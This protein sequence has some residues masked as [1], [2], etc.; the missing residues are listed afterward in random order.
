MPI[1]YLV[2]ILAA[3]WIGA[4]V[5]YWISKL[6]ELTKTRSHIAMACVVA[7]D[8]FLVFRSRPFRTWLW[9][10]T[11]GQWRKIDAETVRPRARPVLSRGRSS[12]SWCSSR[13]R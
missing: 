1:R 13:C 2:R 9:D 5:L 8:L 12:R 4:A 3:V 6:D 11:F 10:V 7:L